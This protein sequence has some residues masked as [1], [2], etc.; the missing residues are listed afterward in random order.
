MSKFGQLATM[1]KAPRPQARVPVPVEGKTTLGAFGMSFD[2]SRAAQLDTFSTVSE[3]FTI[4]DRNADTFAQAA[5]EAE[6]VRKR[7][8]RSSPARH[9]EQR[10]VTSHAVIDLLAE[11]NPHLD[12]YDYFYQWSQGVDLVGE[13]FGLFAGPNGKM[14]LLPTEIWPM[15]SNIMIAV[16]DSREYLG[17]WMHLGPE[18][19]R[20]P[21]KTSEL[22]FTK[23]YNQR[24]PY[25]GIGPIQALMIDLDA[26]RNAAL[27][28]ANFFYN[29]AE[30]GGI[31]EFPD[32][33]SDAD[34]ETFVA[35]WED[36][37]RGVHN[38]H[39]VASI[40][41][42]KWVNRAW[43]MKD[44]QFT[45]LRRMS[46]EQILFGFGFPKT[47]AGQTE[48][49][50]RA[51]ALAA[52][53]VHAH[54]ITRPKLT[55]VKSTFERQLFPKFT[56]GESLEWEFQDPA[57][58]DQELEEQLAESRTSRWVNLVGIGA[59]PDSAAEHVGIEPIT[60]NGFP[61][62]GGS[63]SDNGG[64][65]P[66][67]GPDI[68]ALPHARIE[69][70]RLMAEVAQKVY[71][72]VANKVVTDAEARDVLRMAGWDIPEGPLPEMPEPAAPVP[73]PVPPGLEQEGSLVEVPELEALVRAALG[74]G[75]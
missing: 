75:R 57:P 6:V 10:A 60:W 74:T 65:V 43:S 17:G 66:G 50:N 26:S 70:A 2:T 19:Q 34:W 40:E 37:H 64:V 25:R 58:V 56:G 32:G 29:S 3:V 59:D 33:I 7:S 1:V 47:M 54:G 11:P 41:H 21:V 61:E 73:E 62:P 42:G 67:D 72:A 5:M 14:G 16:P 12:T 31:I 8:R 22:M 63:G 52:M 51:T 18:G 4:V 38:A 28:N 68:D 49:V 24:N 20:T 55:K 44:M 15:P 53:T 9:P 30:P 71:L 48:D 46:R 36:S 13:S 45:D 27:W 39:R 69:E 23:R 35:R